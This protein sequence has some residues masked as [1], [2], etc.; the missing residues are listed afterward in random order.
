MELSKEKMESFLKNHGEIVKTRPDELEW[1]FK[2]K[3]DY[4]WT[5]DIFDNVILYLKSDEDFEET[6]NS[7]E[8]IITPMDGGPELHIVE[9]ANISKYCL[10]DSPVTVPHIWY[11]N[12]LVES[13][14][15]PDE[16]PLDIVSHII[17]KKELVEYDDIGSFETIAKNFRLIKQFIY[18]HK[19]KPVIYRITLLRESV[20]PFVTMNE[21]AVSFATIQYEF[22][23]IITGDYDNT[24]DIIH[25]CVRMIQLITGQMNPLAKTQQSDILTEYN[26]LVKTII[27]IPKWRRDNENGPFFFAPKPITLETHNLIEPSAET[28]GIQSIYSGYAVTD[29][30]DGERMLLYIAKNGIAYLINNTLDVYDTGLYVPVETARESLID[31]EFISIQNRRDNSSYNLFAGFDI[32]FMGGKNTL[33]LPLISDSNTKQSRNSALIQM[34]DKKLWDTRGNARHINIEIKAKEHFAVEGDLMKDTCRAILNNVKKLPYNIDGLI[35]TPSRLSVFGFYPGKEAIITDNMRW[36]K[37]MKWKPPEQNSIDFLVEKGN[38]IKDHVTKKEYVEYKLYMGYNA[39]QWEPISVF[40]GIRLRYEKGYMDA[41]KLTVDSYREKLFRPIDTSTD[42]SIAHIPLGENGMGICDDGSLIENRSIV[43][44]TYIKPDEKAPTHSQSRNWRALRVRDDKTRILH[45]TGKLSKTLNDIS[46]AMNVWRTINAPVTRNM[47][48]G[49]TPVLES[50]LPISLEERLLGADDIYYARTIPREHRLSVHM[51]NFHNHGIKKRLYSMGK[52]DALLELACGMAGDLPR[53]RECGYHFILG[54]DLVKD[55]ITNSREGAY[56]IMLK[57]SKAVSIIIQGVEQKIYPDTIFVVGDCSLP[58]HNGKA[59]EGIDEESRAVLRALFK[60]VPKT[61]YNPMWTQKKNDVLPPQLMGRVSNLFTV[62]SAMFS[63]HYFFKTEETL[64]GFLKNVSS[65]LRKG[66]IFICTFMDGKLVHNLVSKSA[67]GIVDGRKLEA[68]VPVWAIIKRYNE[69][70]EGNYYG[71][72]VD[73]FI[74]NTSR[75]IPEYLVDLDTLIAKAETFDLTLD[76]TALFS[77]DFAILK[78]A[79]P[80]DPNKR[81]RLDLDILEL[82]ND[83]VQT[84]FSFLN[85][86]CCFK[87]I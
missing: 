11:N 2:Y 43:E 34:C 39:V 38:I 27:K 6:I 48:M 5:S 86:W 52:K 20:D 41:H 9:V 16:L 64:N 84:Q 26:N 29:K 30:A 70:G 57:Q 10:S 46:V 82:D 25:N 61:H 33:H 66:G 23:T 54:V 28:Y 83:P 75:L 58:L 24:I 65:N 47:I 69:F 55:N 63:I 31:G 67:S 7:D 4:I 19:K 76:K 59:A 44:F 45:K 32:Y 53:W 60:N 50:S 72:T 73:V 37:E 12:I 18:S 40:E 14:T 35:F 3:T 36:N 22:E 62:V 8:L 1:S 85:R 21:S 17:E 79:I 87:K 81:T 15:L 71:K 42:I 77:E 51:L 13:Q 74:E 68:K 78:D 80:S 56:S 49:I